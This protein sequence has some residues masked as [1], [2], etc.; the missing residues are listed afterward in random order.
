[1]DEEE[2][3]ETPPQDN[4]DDEGRPRRRKG[5][6]GFPLPDDARAA[7]QELRPKLRRR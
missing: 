4:Q 2:K 5:F 7:L 6:D 3:Q 1:M